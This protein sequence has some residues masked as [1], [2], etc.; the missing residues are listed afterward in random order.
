MKLAGKVIS[1]PDGDG[2]RFYHQ[3]LF[4][5]SPVNIP[6]GEMDSETMKIRIAGIDA[7]EVY[8]IGV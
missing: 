8:S 2:F 7:P 6:R 5:C 3:A 1:V 4:G